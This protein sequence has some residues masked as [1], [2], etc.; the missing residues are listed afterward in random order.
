MAAA[1]AHTAR[2][3][4]SGRLST[5]ITLTWSAARSPNSIRSIAP[6]TRASSAARSLVQMH[7]ASG[8]MEFTTILLFGG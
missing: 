7:T 1:S 5:T 3:W 4:P 8:D 6:S 2:A